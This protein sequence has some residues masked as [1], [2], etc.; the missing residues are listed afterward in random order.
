MDL[1]STAL[2]AIGDA[3]TLI[4]QPE[5]MMIL[6]LGVHMGLEVGILPGLGGNAGLTEV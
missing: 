3:F 5:R 4:V 6:V 2:P 1:L